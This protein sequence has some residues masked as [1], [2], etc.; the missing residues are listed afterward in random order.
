[1]TKDKL[2]VEGL[3]GKKTLSGEISIKGAKNSALKAMA[4]AVLFADPITLKNVPDIEDIHKLSDLLVTSG[5]A[6]TFKKAANAKS[7]ATLTIDPSGIKTTDLDS[8][9]AQSMRGS[10]MLTGPMLA[11]YGKV[12]LPI[13]GGCVIGT[14]PIDLYVSA[15]EK[16][17]AKVKLENDSY[18]FTAPKGLKGADIFFNLQTVGGTETLMMAAVL[19]SGTTILR[20]CAMEPEIPALAEYLNEC[21]A[22]IRGAGTSTIEIV[23][24]GMKGLL[25]SGGKAFVTIP[26]RIETAGFLILG[27]LCADNLKITDCDPKH[28]EATIQLLQQS[29]VNVI[30]GKTT[31]EIRDNGKVKNSS[32]TPLTVKTHEYPG[33]PTDVQAPMVAFL[34]QLGGESTIFETIYEGRFKFIQNLELLGAPVTVMNP[35]EIL[36]KGAGSA[37]VANVV[38]MKSLPLGEELDAFDIRAGFATIIAALLAKGTSVIKNAYFIDRGYEDIEGRLGAIGA[39]IRRLRTEDSTAV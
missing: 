27:A 25:K 24:S 6:V 32:L 22:D 30:V 14:R 8:A 3:A 16:M 26:D 9:L 36:V 2:I 35:R 13:P 34:T 39:E 31:L 5:A 10:V 21:G 12:T 17:G 28:L 4:A 11:R 18:V 15:Y 7:T 19:A 38:G 37:N 29:G 20:N 23:G 33:F 1:M